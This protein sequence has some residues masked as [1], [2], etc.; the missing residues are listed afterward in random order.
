MKCW[1]CGGQVADVTT[2][3]CTTCAGSMIRHTYIFKLTGERISHC[4]THCNAYYP[5]EPAAPQPEEGK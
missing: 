4:V 3:A 2:L 5:S 1:C